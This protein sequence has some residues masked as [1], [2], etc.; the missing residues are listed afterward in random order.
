MASKGLTVPNGS[1]IP[2]DDN[3]HRNANGVAPRDNN[4]KA[5]TQPR[6]TDEDL[7]NTFN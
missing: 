5:Y 2:S 6:A 1:A 7:Q 4:R 3:L